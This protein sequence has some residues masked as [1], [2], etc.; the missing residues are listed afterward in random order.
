[1]NHYSL[2]NI[3]I[4]YKSNQA[5]TVVDSLSQIFKVK[6]THDGRLIKVVILLFSYVTTFIRLLCDYLRKERQ[7]TLDLLLFHQQ[8]N[9][10]ELISSEYTNRDR[11]LYYHGHI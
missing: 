9:N 2:N 6:T 11:L 10:G 5:N 4:E 8:L 7:T 3:N 1:M